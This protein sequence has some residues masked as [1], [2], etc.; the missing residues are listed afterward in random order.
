MLGVWTG[1]PVDGEMLGLSVL[2]LHLNG[3]VDSV[4]LG[5]V[6]GALLSDA[7]VDGKMLGG[8]NFTHV[9]VLGRR[10]LG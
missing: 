6:V 7:L 5:L 3:L 8:W 2:F 4:L 10:T 9:G 1:S